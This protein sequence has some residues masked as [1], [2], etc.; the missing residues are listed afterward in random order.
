MTTET[1]KRV[2]RK[3]KRVAKSKA[4][5]GGAKASGTFTTVELAAEQN[6]QAKTLRA[7]IRRNID[8]W[9]PLFADGVKHVFKDNKTTR[10]K[11]E[12]LLA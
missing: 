7:R 5:A 10:A 12:Q 4:A 3:T 1:K 2:V 11:I 8:A 6:I 9:S